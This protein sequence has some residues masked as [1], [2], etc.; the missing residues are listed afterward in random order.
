MSKKKL[1]ETKVGIFLKE[2]APQILDTIGDVLPSSGGLGVIKNLISKDHSM[3]K[4]DKEMAMKMVEMDMAEMSEVSERWK[5]DMGSDSWLS[6][7]TRPL[8]LMF[9]TIA[10]TVFILIDSFA[11][12]NFNVKEAWVDLL[13]TLLTTVYIAYFGSRGAEKWKNISNNSNK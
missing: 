7:N 10:M 13:Q 3:S 5:A 12:S 4:E 9:L 11:M 1:S 6:K 8:S 2:K